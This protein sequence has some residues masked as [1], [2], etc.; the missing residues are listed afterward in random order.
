MRYKFGKIFINN[1]IN[2]KLFEVIEYDPS[3]DYYTYI[4]NYRDE[5]YDQVIITSELMIDTLKVYFY[6]KKCTITHVELLE[7]DT[8][9]ENEIEEILN[10]LRIDRGYFNLLLEKLKCLIE[11]NSIDIRK[12]ELQWR[13][14]GFTTAL[15]MQVNGLL[16][17]TDEK[18]DSEKDKVL[19]IIKSKFIKASV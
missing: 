2:T 11:K 6:D 10:Q 4:K 19:D 7:H 17:I 16:G 3:I 14:D 12:I 5:G 13:E 9:M 18:Y 8:Q 1:N 15:F